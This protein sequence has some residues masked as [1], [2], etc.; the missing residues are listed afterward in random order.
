MIFSRGGRGLV[1]YCQRSAPNF[2]LPGFFYM[3]FG[4]FSVPVMTR[5]GVE[6]GKCVGKIFFKSRFRV[7]K[8][9][10]REILLNLFLKVKIQGL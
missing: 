10:R 1:N 8:W 5:C 4:E 6:G 9:R 2:S 7:K 3:E